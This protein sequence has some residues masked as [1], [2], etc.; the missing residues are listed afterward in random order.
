M[1]QLCTFVMQCRG[2]SVLSPTEVDGGRG[3]D[4]GLSSQGTRGMD[5]LYPRGLFRRS[6]EV[7]MSLMREHAKTLLILL[8]TL[9][10]DPLVDWTPAA[11]QVSF[12]SAAHGGR[13]LTEQVQRRQRLQR[14]L[15]WDMLAVRIKEIATGWAKN[16]ELVSSLLPELRSSLSDLRSK[17]V[18]LKAVDDEK[19]ARLKETLMLREAEYQPSHP[20]YT[21]S[22]FRH[23]KESILECKA[24]IR[25]ELQSAAELSNMHRVVLTASEN[26]VAQIDGWLVTVPSNKFCVAPE[27][28]ERIL[29]YLQTSGQQHLV[30]QVLVGRS[31]SHRLLLRG[32]GRVRSVRA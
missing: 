31:R 5:E 27:S 26:V 28:M 3:S 30:Q 16:K 32:V 7:V 19:Q 22:C 13:G 8:E 12:A 23:I 25:R 2:S 10:Y 15:T 18:R 6:C 9:V 14:D 1:D 21:Y 17:V 29:E 20:L 4:C 24:L 11:H